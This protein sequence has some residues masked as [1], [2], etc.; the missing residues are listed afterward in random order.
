MSAVTQAWL[1]DVVFRPLSPE[2]FATFHEPDYVKIAWTLRADPFNTT[3]AI[4]RSETGLVTTDPAA[5]AKFRR[6]WAFASPA[7]S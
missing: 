7:S 2:E 3:E 6:Y 5:R 1:A 4:F